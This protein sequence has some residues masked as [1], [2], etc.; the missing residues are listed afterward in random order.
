MGI[1]ILDLLCDGHMDC[2]N[3]LASI[4]GLSTICSFFLDGNII[5][6][7]LYTPFWAVY[8]WWALFVNQMDTGILLLIMLED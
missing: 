8:Y 1:Q 3:M 2:N 5:R 4:T 6:I 7:L